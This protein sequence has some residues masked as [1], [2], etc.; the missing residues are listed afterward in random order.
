MSLFSQN[1]LANKYMY[2]YVLRTLD[3]FDWKIDA[4]LIEVPTLQFRI[5]GNFFIHVQRVQMRWVNHVNI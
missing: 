5:Q 1:Y 4:K 2:E 3:I